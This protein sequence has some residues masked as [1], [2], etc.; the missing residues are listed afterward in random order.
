[1]MRIAFV[2]MI[3]RKSAQANLS[4]IKRAFSITCANKIYSKIEYRPWVFS[5]F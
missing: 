1:M 4:G 5:L 2:W 3:D